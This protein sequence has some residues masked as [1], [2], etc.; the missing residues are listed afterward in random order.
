VEFADV[1]RSRRMVRSF[2]LAAVDSRIVE[3]CVDL[4]GRAPSAGKSQGWNLILLEGTDV[5]RY[6]DV[7]LPQD[8]RQGFAFPGLLRAPMILIS[9]ADPRSYLDRYSEADKSATGLGSSIEKW[10]APYWTIDASFSTMTLL[11]ALE[12][13]GLGALFF[14]HANEPGVRAEFAIP[15]EV[16]ILGV[17]ALGHPDGQDR[18]SGRSASRTRRDVSDVIHRS[19]W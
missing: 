11:L 12:D 7:A 15:D 6:W 5:P 10:P 17:I 8:R 18:T 3:R 19:R 13:E 2:S 4:A 16:Q 1:V 14:A 9:T